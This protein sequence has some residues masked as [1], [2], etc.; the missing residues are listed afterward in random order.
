MVRNLLAHLAKLTGANHRVAA[1]GPRLVDGRWKS[2]ERLRPKG[3][4]VQ[5]DHLLEVDHVIASGA[6]LP[7]AP[8]T[9]VGGM[10]EGL[11]IDF[12]DIEWCQRALQGGHRCSIATDAMDYLLGPPRFLIGFIASTWPQLSTR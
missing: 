3:D 6:L 11:F 5:F 7:M 2:E 9:A 12:V 10:R 8:L 4:A 1:I